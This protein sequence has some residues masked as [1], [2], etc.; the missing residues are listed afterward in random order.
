MK[1]IKPFILKEYLFFT[2]IIIAQYRHTYYY[3]VTFAHII[4]DVTE[5]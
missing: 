4:Q 5:E 2:D 3:T 1:S